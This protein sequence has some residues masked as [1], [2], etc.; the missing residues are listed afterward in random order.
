MKTVLKKVDQAAWIFDNNTSLKHKWS[1]RGHGNS[2]ILN[3]YNG[4]MIAKASG[5][6]YD[7]FGAVLGNTIEALFQ[8]ELNKIAKNHCKNKRSEQRVASD[9]FYGLFF[10]PTTGKAYLDGACGTSCMKTILNK[11]GFTLKYN[12]QDSKTNSGVEFYELI[13]ITKNDYKYL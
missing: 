4:G 8:D 2:K 10:N 1:S 12:G 3:G 7:R 9:K 6:G 5:C 11:I 13:A